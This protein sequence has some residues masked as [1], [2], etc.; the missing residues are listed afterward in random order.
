MHT[1]KAVTNAQ[2]AVSATLNKLFS[3]V[4]CIQRVLWLNGVN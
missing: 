2:P 1:V 3:T 4:V